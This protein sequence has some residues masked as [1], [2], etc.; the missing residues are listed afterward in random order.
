MDI[1]TTLNSSPPGSLPGTI[2]V[3]QLDNDDAKTT[4]AFQPLIGRPPADERLEQ[5]CV[6]V[7]LVQNVFTLRDKLA[8]VSPRRVETMPVTQIRL[9]C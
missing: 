8:G 7:R 4:S 9:I 1:D 3:F 5:V 2:H 6:A